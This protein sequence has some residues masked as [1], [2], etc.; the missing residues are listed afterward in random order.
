MDLAFGYI[1]HTLQGHDE[2]E[3]A[4][5]NEHRRLA[6]DRAAFAAER[7]ERA[8]EHRTLVQRVAE[9]MRLAGHDSSGARAAH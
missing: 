3:A 2:L 6:A 1:S 5:V 9:R 8:A 7:T 4:R